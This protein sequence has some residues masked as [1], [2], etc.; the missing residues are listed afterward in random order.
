MPKNGFPRTLWGVVR[1]LIEFLYHFFSLD[2]AWIAGVILEHLLWVFIFAAATVI[3]F[4]AQKHFWGFVFFVFLVWALVDVGA[5]TGWRLA[6]YFGPAHFV[7]ASLV[8]FAFLEKNGKLSKYNIPSVLVVLVSI[9]V[10]ITFFGLRNGFFLVA[11]EG[12][13]VGRGACVCCFIVKRFWIYG[14]C[15]FD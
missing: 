7:L 12:V 10:F 8:A 13:F 6:N 4:P 3:I 2:F 14:V 5:Y 1:M 9:W 11:F 15:R